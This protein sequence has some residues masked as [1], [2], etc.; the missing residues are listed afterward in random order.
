M[1][2]TGTTRFWDMYWHPEA[3][4]RA[5]RD[6]GLTATVG[7]PLFD[8][9]GGTKEMQATALENLDALAAHADA[10]IAPCLAPPSI[11]TV[12]SELL[13]WT[14]ETAAERGVPIQIHLSETE[15]EVEECL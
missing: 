2:R 8:A 6:A 5:V 12:S 9:E 14:A 3:T 11:Y 13:R 15:A 10:G 4:A 1:I 7:G